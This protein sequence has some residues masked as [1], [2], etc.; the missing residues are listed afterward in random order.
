MP[1]RRLLGKIGSQRLLRLAFRLNADSE[2]ILYND[3]RITRRQVFAS[4]QALG[5]G[6]Q[7]LGVR[8]GDRVVTLLPACPE[9]I[10]TMFLPQTIGSVNVPLHPLLGDRELKHI[11]ADC[12]ARVVITTKRWYGQDYPA[13]LARLLPELPDLRHVIVA[14]LEEGDGKIFLPLGEVMGGDKRLRTEKISGDELTLITYT[15]GT[16]GLPKGVMHTPR[17]N[18]SLAVRAVNPRLDLRLMRCLLLPLPP[19]QFGGMLGTVAALLAGGKV[20]LMERFDPGLMLQWIEREKVTQVVGSPTM[21]RLMLLSAGQERRDLSSL[22]RVTFSTEP[23]PPELVRALHERLGCHLENMYGTTE[24]MMISWTGAEDTWERAA[25]TV[26][27]PVPG[28]QV[29]IVDEQRRPVPAGEQGEIAVRT[30]QM[31]LG[32]YNAPELTSQ[33]LDT[34]GWF[35]T[36]DIGYVGDDGFLRL[37]DRKSDMIIRGGQNVYPVEVENHLNNHTAIRRAAVFG[38]P[39]AL[40]GESIWAYIEPQPGA[41]LTITEVLNHCRGQIAPFKIPEEVRFIERLPATPTGKI[42]KY[43]LRELALQ[44]LNRG[45]PHPSADF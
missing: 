21:Y 9:S 6:L 27:K 15:S 31:M 43:Q 12:Q 36:G 1:L 30:L 17:R 42:Q 13:R 7:A 14:G 41:A 35:Y 4:I 40:T 18:F 44:E 23:C 2:L 37:V 8:K 24:S 20:V 39:H 10:Y 33:V 11:L 32:Y 34:E 45:E 5:A 26:G 22:R 19:Y 16:T 3:Q 38:M 25:T 28:A 29:R